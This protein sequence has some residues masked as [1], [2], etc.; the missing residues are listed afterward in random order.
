MI[1]VVATATNSV[2]SSPPASNQTSAV[3]GAPL[4]TSPPTIS[5]SAKVGQKLTAGTGGWTGYP[6]PTYAYHWQRCNRNGSSCSAVAGATATTY[7][8]TK[9]DS[10]KTIRVTVKATN[11]IGA[12]SATS[13]ATA[14]V[15]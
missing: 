9:T 4:N 15:A 5:G 11:A 8:L 1:Q 10:G 12:A 2:G 13:A 14:V 3:T 7:S 6:A